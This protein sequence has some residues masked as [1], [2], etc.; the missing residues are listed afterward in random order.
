MIELS[1][2]LLLILQGLK[3]KTSSTIN[4][5]YLALIIVASLWISVLTGGTLLLGLG[6][7][8]FA[9]IALVQKKHSNL[10]EFL[11][12]FGLMLALP[13]TFVLPVL[14]VGLIMHTNQA[15]RIL[16]SVVAIIQFL[17][18]TQLENIY[19]IYSTGV[20]SIFLSFLYAWKKEHGLSLLWLVVLLKWIPLNIMESI[21]FGH[22][23]SLITLLVLVSF[24][25][26]DSRLKQ[27]Q[28]ILNQSLN[29][30]V[31][32]LSL[33]THVNGLLAG[34]LMWLAL[35]I[36]LENNCLGKV[37]ST[38]PIKSLMSILLVPLSPTMIF[39]IDGSSPLDYTL[40]GLILFCTLY[41]CWNYLLAR[42][43]QKKLV[44]ID[45]PK[46]IILII[47]IVSQTFF[48]ENSL[49]T[50]F[51]PLYVHLSVS[52]IFILLFVVLEANKKLEIKNKFLDKI[53][54]SQQ[55]DSSIELKNKELTIIPSVQERISDIK[56]FV[57]VNIEETLTK[58]RNSIAFWGFVLL[59]IV[60]IFGG[61]G[62]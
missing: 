34:L 19:L 23:L 15:N 56:D 44:D 4:V 24:S 35:E 54:L 60:L 36:L 62:E 48:I 41:L 8:L 45:V 1:S 57:I 14:V 5:I 22:V 25:L 53:K 42:D 37:L 21:S 38:I 51:V 55:N 52:I 39:L 20:I 27:Q 28:T 40:Q 29:I 43:E 13:K 61:Q 31:I 32:A 18:I 7:L 12:I 2:V 46:I 9:G 10:I 30:L 16:L 3:D 6:V 49:R 47:Y 33:S 50:S 59:I 11:P 58:T 26:S 17:L